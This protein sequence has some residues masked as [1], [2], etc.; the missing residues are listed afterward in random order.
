MNEIN[1]GY[2]LANKYEVINKLGEGGFGATFIVKSLTANIT[3]QFVA[4]CQK[5]TGNYQENQNLIERFEKE[6]IALQRLGSSHGQVPSLFDYFDYEG[7]FY[8]IQEL[9][10][11]RT[12]MD[13]FIHLEQEGYVFSERKASEIIASLLEIIEHIHEQGIIHRDIKPQNIILREGDEKPVLIDFGL[14][15]Q[16][17]Q[18]NFHKTGTAVGTIGYCPIEQQLGKAF[19]QS[20]LYAVG[21][22]MLLLTTGRP[23][24]TLD[25]NDKF[26]PDLEWANSLINSNLLDWITKAIHPLPQTRFASAS[27]MRKALLEM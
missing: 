1:N 24:H 9:V 10:R 15:K 16:I 12:L 21:M 23:P 27:E 18:D 3:T 5:M 4:K 2:R 19:F 22:T 17:D 6:A 7:N 14:V 20:A 13:I 25:F 26:E 11:G 8:I